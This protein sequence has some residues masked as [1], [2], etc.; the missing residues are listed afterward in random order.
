[1]LF[2]GIETG[3]LELNDRLK[4][5]SQQHKNRREMVITELTDMQRKQ[6]GRSRACH[7]TGR[8]VAVTDSD[9]SEDRGGGSHTQQTLL[10]VDTI[11]PGLPQSHR[12]RNTH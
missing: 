11:Q 1:M 2:E 10:R 7:R 8:E 9:P 6:Q 5:R 3:I 12:Q 4:T